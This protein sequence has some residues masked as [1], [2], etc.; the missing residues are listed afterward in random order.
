MQICNF[1]LRD[2]FTGIDE[3]SNYGKSGSVGDAKLE[4]REKVIA[5]ISAFRIRM[6]LA[7]FGKALEKGQ[8]PIVRRPFG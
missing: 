6:H 3:L 8:E 2:R 1:C 4:S 7:G 5:R